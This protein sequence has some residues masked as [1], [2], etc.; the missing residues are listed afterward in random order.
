MTD[1]PTVIESEKDSSE[2]GIFSKLAPLGRISMNYFFKLLDAAAVYRDT[3]NRFSYDTTTNRLRLS[4]ESEHVGDRVH[5]VRHLYT[6]M[7]LHTS[8][9]MMVGMYAMLGSGELAASSLA[10]AMGS[11]V[12]ALVAAG[13]GAMAI[14]GVEAFQRCE[15]IDYTTEPTPDVDDID[16]QYLDGE[17]DEQE[18]EARKEARLE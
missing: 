11:L 8:A 18:L 5:R 6:S 2:G 12:L 10:S 7:T 4:G 16:Q 14:A 3:G 1:A 15:I 13:A 9:W 17:I